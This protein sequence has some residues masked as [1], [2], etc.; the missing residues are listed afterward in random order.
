MLLSSM[1]GNIISFFGPRNQ[2]TI[3]E[4]CKPKPKDFQI[5]VEPF[6]SFQL[7]SAGGKTNDWP[8]AQETLNLENGDEATKTVRQ[9]SIKFVMHSYYVYPS[10]Q[11]TKII[12]VGAAGRRGKETTRSKFKSSS[13][14]EVAYIISSIIIDHI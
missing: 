1:G 2:A 10:C 3:L 14:Y 7:R 6:T 5:Q 13:K 9:L 4:S 12:R 8:L 11:P